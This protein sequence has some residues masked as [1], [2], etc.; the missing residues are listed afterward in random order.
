MKA[1]TRSVR[2]TSAEPAI[3]IGENRA[4]ARARHP[5]TE[6]EAIAWLVDQ[7]P[8]LRPAFDEHLKDH[9]E[10]LPYVVF[11]GDFLRWFIARVERGDQGPARRFVVP[12]EPLLMTEA[13]PLV[14]ILSGISPGSASWSASGTNLTLLTW[15]GRGWAPTPSRR[16]KS[17]DKPDGALSRCFTT[18]ASSGGQSWAD[19]SATGVP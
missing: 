5:P 18:A 6:A 3:L 9:D 11:E 10:V 12:I 2:L 17:L 16:L 15:L 8:E 4:V 19:R 7:V 14:T 1:V 13:V